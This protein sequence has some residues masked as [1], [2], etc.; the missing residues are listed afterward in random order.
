M[1]NHSLQA[2][3]LSLLLFIANIHVKICPILLITFVS[4]LYV[5]GT[6]LL[7]FSTSISEMESKLN[8]DLAYICW[9]SV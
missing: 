4:L 2:S 8:L 5:D 9:L 7:Y 1:S 6:V 3:I